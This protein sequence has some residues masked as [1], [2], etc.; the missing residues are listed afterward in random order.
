MSRAISEKQ[1]N[2]L[3]NA[4][5]SYDGVKAVTSV[6]VSGNTTPTDNPVMDIDPLAERRL[7]RKIDLFIVPIVALLYL[8]CFLDRANI[9]N[10]RLAGLEKDLHM[11]GNDYNAVTSVFYVSYVLFGLPS[12]VACKWIGPG[13]YL[14]TIT[15]CFGLVSLST[16]FVQNRAQAFAVRFLLG[17]CESGLM[18]GIA[19]YL[20]RWYRRRELAFRLALYVVMAPLSGAFGGLLASAILHLRPVG[21]LN[22]PWRLLFAFE[23]SLTVGVG[24]VALATL[25]DRPATARWL[26]PAQRRLAA[27]RIHVDKLDQLDRLNRTLLWRGISC[28][29]TVTTAA[30]LFCSNITVS[31]LGFFLP[32]II[33]T[34]FP[35]KPTTMQQLY[36]VPPYAVGALA[37]ILISLWSD[38]I[39][40]RQVFML[41][42]AVPVIAGYIIFLGTS[43]DDASARYVATFLISGAAFVMGTLT[44]AQISANVISDTARSSAL[45]T[46]VVL[47][48]LGGIVSTWSFLESD[49]PMYRIGN[50]INLAASIGILV[51]SALVLLFMNTS[52]R[53]RDSRNAAKLTALEGLSEQE[54]QALD[55]KHPSFRWRS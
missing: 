41:A 38:R 55:W 20:T 2:I 17:L 39:D 50:S 18:P 14:P 34:I 47:G 44:N 35:E 40:R 3:A 28:P 25:T 23:G 5:S 15:L 49:A 42:S 1:E 16:A 31:G 22:A 53:Q 9:G 12:M 8:F 52:N 46:N 10:A 19:Y 21:S 4:P 29:V 36:T 33:R 7:R 37:T 51:L 48:G 30:I 54:L 45:A 26:T 43:P 32:T 24:L 13:W 11:R 27:A 6:V